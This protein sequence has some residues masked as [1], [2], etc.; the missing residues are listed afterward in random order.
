MDALSLWLDDYGDIYSDFDSRHY[1]KRR[2]SEDFIRELKIASR[3]LEDPVNV[4]VLLLPK[5][6]RK[7]A[8]EKIINDSLRDH[9][10]GEYYIHANNLRKKSGKN[11][12]FFITG[13]LAMCA[14]VFI[15][16]TTKNTLVTSSL[17]VLLEPAGWF[18]LWI[19]LDF[20][21]YDFSDLKKERDFYKKL[22]ELNIHF[23]S[24]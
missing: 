6:K 3:N 10:L 4:L 12:L 1:L 9:F 24:A 17:K 2:V 13:I 8:S 18:F 16:Y 23:K 20:L 21:F 22:S 15:T 11:L 7:D 14:N 5:E 19:S